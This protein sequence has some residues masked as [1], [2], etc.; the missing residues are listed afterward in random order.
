MSKRLDKVDTQEIKLPKSNSDYGDNFNGEEFCTKNTRKNDKKNTSYKIPFYEKIPKNQLAII[1]SCILVV[2]IVIGIVVVS[3]SSQKVE[4]KDETTTSS[5]ISTIK[6]EKKYTNPITNEHY[7][8]DTQTKYTYIEE[9]ES[10]TQA[11]ST[12]IVTTI[13]PTTQVAKTSKQIETTVSPTVSF[14]TETETET[15]TATYME[16]ILSVDDISVIKTDDNLFI[17]TAN[18]TFDGYSDEELL[19]LVSIS[20]T[21][22]TPIISSPSI[23][24]STFSF[25]IGLSDECDGELCIHFGNYDY[26]Q[27][28]SSMS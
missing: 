18:G 15:K 27:P 16:K 22:G 5:S 23:N 25:Y 19:N 20:A 12:E 10:T 13:Q 9:E 3:L 1:S 14:E 7:N 4:K 8:K 17:C 28:I 11:P 2:I 24:G 26:Y 21:S 6:E